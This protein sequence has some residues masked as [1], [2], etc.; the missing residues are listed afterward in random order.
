MLSTA[1]AL[2]SN[3]VTPKCF[4]LLKGEATRSEYSPFPSSDMR[5]SSRMCLIEASAT[6]VAAKLAT[7]SQVR[8]S[9]QCR[10]GWDEG[11]APKV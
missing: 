2:C 8:M 6:C 9:E 11:M 4:G 3:V 5:S 10:S 1:A 7:V